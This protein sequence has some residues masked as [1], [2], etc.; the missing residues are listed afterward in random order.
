MFLTPD[1]LS[2]FILEVPVFLHTHTK[3]ATTHFITSLIVLLKLRRR[4]KGI[5]YVMLCAF[6]YALFHQYFWS[7]V[8]PVSLLNVFH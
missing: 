3:R 5:C 8:K 6:L 7:H 2:R 4:Y 1:S